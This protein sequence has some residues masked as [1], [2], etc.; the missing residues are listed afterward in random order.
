MG[1]L[2][3][4]DQLKRTEIIDLLKQGKRVDGRAF[5]EPSPYFN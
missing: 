4:I 2:S 3:V 5:D 1:H